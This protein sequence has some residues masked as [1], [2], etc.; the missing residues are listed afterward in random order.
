MDVRDERG[1]LSAP[2]LVGLLV[3]VRH[4]TTS[5]IAGAEVA[6]AKFVLPLNVAV[7]AKV[8]RVVK[9]N[10][11]SAVPL[12]SC[13]D[14]TPLPLTFSVTEPV[15]TPAADE[16]VA[17]NVTVELRVVGFCDDVSVTVVDAGVTV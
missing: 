5:L 9:R 13:C 7:T 2:L 10:D 14:A 15:G 1:P 8:P 11:R 16:T 3:L 4:C 6:V 17:V 12:V